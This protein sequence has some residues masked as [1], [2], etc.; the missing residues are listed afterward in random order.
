MKRQFGESA[1]SKFLAGDC[2]ALSYFK[3]ID[4]ERAKLALSEVSLVDSKNGLKRRFFR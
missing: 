1:G 3:F 2:P 4:F